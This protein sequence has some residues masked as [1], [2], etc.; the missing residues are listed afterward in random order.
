MIIKIDCNQL[1]RRSCKKLNLCSVLKIGEFN[2][3]KLLLNSSSIED[4]LI[5]WYL[6]KINNNWTSIKI[7]TNKLFEEV[8]SLSG[9]RLGIFGQK[10]KVISP[11]WCWLLRLMVCNHNI[12]ICINTRLACCNI[13]KLVGLKE[14]LSNKSWITGVRVAQ[15]E[16]RKVNKTILWD[17]M[18][19][20][21]KL[22]PILLW[23]INQII[24]CIVCNQLSY[25][26]IQNIGFSSIGC[27]PCTRSIK[28][29]EHSRSGR[30]WW[31][32]FNKTSSECGLHRY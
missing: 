4:L 2:K 6:S 5:Y 9:M 23:N 13:R 21:I 25:N 22:S 29:N 17:T 19:N 30:W 26:S 3:C 15:S 32:S 31:E 20:S 18:H 10:N 16:F 27:S 11:K 7:N 28:H 24:N 14:I 12:Y 8:L 1:L